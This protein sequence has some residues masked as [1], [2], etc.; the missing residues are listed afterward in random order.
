MEGGCRE[1]LK[2]VAGGPQKI[3]KKLSIFLD[4]IANFNIFP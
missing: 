1:S 3:L 2:G 4:G